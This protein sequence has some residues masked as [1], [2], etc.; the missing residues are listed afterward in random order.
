MGNEDVRAVVI[1]GGIHGL[2]SAIA[3][4]RGG[5][6]VSL[7]EKNSEL[8]SGTSGATQ[9]RAHLGYHYPRSVETAEECKK[10]LEVFQE[11][12]PGALVFPD[13]AYYLIEAE[14]SKTSG[15]EF[16]RFC[17]KVNI[18]YE[19]E[20]P[21]EGFVNPDSIRES[22]KV[23]EPVFDLDTLSVLLRKEA[24]E[25]GIRFEMGTEVVDADS[26]GGGYKIVTRRGE[27]E[28]FLDA[29][30]VLNATYAGANRVMNML[31]LNED[32][33]KYVLQKTEVVVA[34]SDEEIPALT[35]MDGDYV[36]VL[37][38]GRYSRRVLLYDVIHSVI[39]RKK[40]FFDDMNK[41]YSTNL[42]KMVEHGE[43]YFPFIG[44]LKYVGSLYGARPIP[45][46][47]TGDS[48]KTRIVAHDRA[49]GVYSILEG[50]FISAPL[51][52][53]EVVRKMKDDGVLV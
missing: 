11:R 33:T 20:M 30:V 9:N 44:G 51:V 24:L 18:P 53:D 6:D 8:L 46:R 43:K 1:G 37:P 17:E 38:F 4:A 7:V 49:P 45:Q 48:R 29:D 34:E 2:T 40:G 13:G 12:Y 47:I 28:G 39:D 52:A 41:N 22:F 15:D 35:I 27:D 23:P 26:V 50:K 14:S 25:L 5:A 19:M 3:L 21:K 32:M 42:E 10:G 31:G 16:A 36:S